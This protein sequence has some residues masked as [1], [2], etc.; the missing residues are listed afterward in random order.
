MDPTMW[1]YAY[2]VPSE[3]AG[4]QQLKKSRILVQLK[5]V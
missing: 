1:K 3:K 2:W 4:L 5:K